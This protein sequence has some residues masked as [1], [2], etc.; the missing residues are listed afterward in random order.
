MVTKYGSN[1][2]IDSVVI[3]TWQVKFLIFDTNDSYA[4]V[5]VL[6]TGEPPLTNP[7]LS[8]SLNYLHLDVI[9]QFLRKQ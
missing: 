2:E 3:F 8:S 6:S 1:A 9:S 7:H 4:F 5:K